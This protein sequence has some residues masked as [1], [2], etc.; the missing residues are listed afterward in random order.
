MK[1]NHSIEAERS[2]LG[3]LL[4]DHSQWLE[5]I[6]KVA[7][8]D[9]YDDQNKMVF[10]AIEKIILEFGM[11][12][13]VN[14]FNTANLLVDTQSAH[15]DCCNNSCVYDYIKKL[16]DDYKNIGNALAYAGIIRE[17]S[18][19][20][21]LVKAADKIEGLGCDDVKE[22]INKA[23]KEVFGTNSEKL[24]KHQEEIKEKDEEIKYQKELIGELV[25][26]LYKAEME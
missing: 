7:S 22:I 5:V 16:S 10:W 17:K 19:L 24:D 3:L 2:L 11:S 26:L 9:F 14:A 4:N 13:K 15:C 1:S 23:E 18:V 8:V 21:Q 12:A 25:G 20:R 6:E